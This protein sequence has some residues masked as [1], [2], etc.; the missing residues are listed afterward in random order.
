MTRGAFQFFEHEHFFD[1]LA[2]GDT[3]MR[4]HLRFAAPLGPLGR[5]MERVLLRQYMDTFLRQRNDAMKRVA[6][7][8][9]LWQ[10]YLE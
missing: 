1:A 7:S 2:E 6:E 8:A 10:R 5:M 9:E 3:L 4:D